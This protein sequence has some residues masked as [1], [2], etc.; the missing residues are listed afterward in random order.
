VAHQ[1]QFSMS[2][3]VII[4]LTSLGYHRSL[5]NCFGTRWRWRTWKRWKE[6]CR[7]GPADANLGVHV[8]GWSA[9]TSCRQRQ[10]PRFDNFQKY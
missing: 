6:C 7:G 9:E 4:S 3:E 2:G 10:Q 1:R 5:L 8:R